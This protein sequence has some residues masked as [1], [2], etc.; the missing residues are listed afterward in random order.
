MSAGEGAR[1][2]AER[3][4]AAAAA[5]ERKAA[6]ARVRAENFESGAVGE[7]AV[8]AAVAP[9]TIAGW[10]VLHDRSL[11]HGGNLDHVLVGPGGVF[12]LDAKNWSGAVV[13]RGGVLRSG[14]RDVT[15]AVQQLSEGVSEVRASLVAAGQQG[16]VEGAL[17]LTHERNADLAPMRAAGVLVTG[18]T[19][20]VETLTA[21]QA[22]LSTA[23]VEA[24]VRHLTLAF[25][26]AGDREVTAAVSEREREDKS[27]PA[28]ELYR[29]ANTYLY[30]QPWAR[31]GRH[32]LYVSDETGLSLGYKDTVSGTIAITEPARDAVVR[33]ILAHATATSLAIHA[34]AL[35]K[36][37]I[38]VR[39][40]RL[41]GAMTRIWM[42]FHVG[43]RWRKAS[44]DRLYG[45]RADPN[46]GAVELGHVDLATGRTHPVHREPLGKDL[47]LPE[48]YLA[49]LR[50]HF[51][52]AS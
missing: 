33:G 6:Y 32:R 18:L 5:L 51:P 45:W 26:G 47:D 39:G 48:K 44:A 27:G 41:L 23:R 38:E 25:P 11:P 2:E 46:L 40:G 50:D 49:R 4:A 9:L 19:Q 1:R 31:A 21:G 42:T 8:A 30:V 35:P 24:A 15:R 36:I 3:A 10:F 12:V 43:Y 29:R 16:A 7:L 52:A 20:L 17:V 37:P 34:E 14:G 13:T 28:A 22:V